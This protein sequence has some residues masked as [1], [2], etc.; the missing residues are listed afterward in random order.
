MN[1]SKQKNKLKS[2]N[3]IKINGKIIETIANNMFISIV[4]TIIELAFD[5]G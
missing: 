2:I 3:I 4:P 5:F 1:K